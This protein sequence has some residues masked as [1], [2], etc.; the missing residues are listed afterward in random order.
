MK[1]ITINLYEYAELSDTAK[2]R[3]YKDWKYDESNFD[4][5][6]L[7]VDLDNRISELLDEH[8]IKPIDGTYAKVLY[9]LGHSQGDGAMFEGVFNWNGY[10]VTIKHSGHYYH[11]NSKVITIKDEDAN[12]VDTDEPYE[13]FEVIY[14]KIC[15]ELETYGYDVI[16]NM[17]SESYFIELCHANDYTFEESGKINNEI[18]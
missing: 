6:S 12:T 4:A 10:T 8:K 1:T 14:Q 3:A 18:M 5:Y 11:S 16:E 9:S 15:K 13:A 17:E 7:Q 2:K